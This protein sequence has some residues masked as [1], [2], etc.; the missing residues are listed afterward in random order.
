[1]ALLT[2]GLIMFG[3]IHLVPSAPKLRSNMIKHL[4]ERGYQ[5]VFAG[6]A[7]AGLLLIIIGKANAP[8]VSLWSPPSWGDTAA[9]VL[10]PIAFILLVGAYLPSNIKRVTAHPMLWGV[11]V[12]AVA[13]LLANGDL[14]SLILF[15]GLG[16]LALVMMG[17]SQARGVV[18]PGPKL[19]VSKD[20]T[21]VA[22]G[23][24]AYAILFALHPYLFG[25]TVL[26]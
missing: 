25:V 17:S 22:V 14:A 11:E 12:W 2:L 19:P 7:L 10:M 4:S 18:A 8:F 5:A 16:T 24:I 23:L 13:H 21:T 3:G 6:T 26:E 20:L 9:L 1:M 15:G